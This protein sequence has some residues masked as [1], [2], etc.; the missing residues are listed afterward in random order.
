[1]A[2]LQDH[3]SYLLRPDA[4]AR[5]VV[6]VRDDFASQHR[7][8]RHRHEKAQL[9]HASSGVMTVT[10]DDGTFVIPPE[11]AVWVPGGT[12]HS[13]L[14]SGQVTMRTVYIDALGEPS[15]PT[16]CAVVIVAPLLRELIWRAVAMDPLYPLG[17]PEERLMEVLVDEV[18]SIEQTALHLPIPSDPRLRRV[19]DALEANPAD[20]RGLTDWAVEAGASPR[21]LDR[22]FR[23]ET[24]MSFSAWRQQLRLLRALEQLASGTPVTEVALALGYESTSA[25]IAMFRRALGDTPGRYFGKPVPDDESTDS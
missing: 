9:V 5:K 20:D 4:V 16:C 14:M 11:R 1:M 13:I 23:Q 21:T 7:I 10:T 3:P 2:N 15:L 6:G 19:T 18:R 8:P 22:L 12:E 24:E 25:F 17:G